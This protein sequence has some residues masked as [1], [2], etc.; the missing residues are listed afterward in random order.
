[1]KFIP[2]NPP[3]RPGQTVACFLCH[4]TT[5]K[6]KAID[7]K[8]HGLF[9]CESCEKEEIM[10]TKSYRV[11]RL[12]FNGGR[13]VIHTG[14]TLEQAQEHCSDPETSSKTCKKAHNV[15]RTRS[16]G[17]WFDSFEEDR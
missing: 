1:M 17:P 14:L 2:I 3:L 4:A 11:V 13:R 10:V 16:R 9:V 6:A 12:Y 15:K 5:T 7:G 8:T